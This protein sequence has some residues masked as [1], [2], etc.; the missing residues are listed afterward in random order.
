MFTRP[1]HQAPA[2]VPAFVLLLSLGMLATLSG[3][4]LANP[5]PDIII[6][7]HVQETSG[8]GYCGTTVTECASV[9]QSTTLTGQLDFQF[10]Y[11]RYYTGVGEPTLIEMTVEWPAG[12]VPLDA[13][14][15]TGYGD[16]SIGGNSAS[17]TIYPDGAPE[18][19]EFFLLAS[20]RMFAGP[21]QTSFRRPINVQTIP[22]APS[23]YDWSASGVGARVGLECG[24]CSSYCYR[25]GGVGPCWPRFDPNPLTLTAAVGQLASATVRVASGGLTECDVTYQ[26]SEP[27]MQL[28]VVPV[29]P[30]YEDDVTVTADATGLSPG[31]Y[32][33]WINADVGDCYECGKV[34]LTVVEG[35]LVPGTSDPWLAGMPDGS[36]ASSGDVAPAQSPAQV[37]G[38]PAV[39]GA[40][41]L[42]EATGGV[43]SGP[44][45][46]L[47]PPDGDAGIIA[48]HN[49]GVEN[50]ISSLTAPYHCLVGIFLDDGRPDLTAAP[51]S[52]DFSTAVSR[53]YSTLRPELKQPF[54][55]GDG[56]TS[57]GQ[58]QG[59]VVS[60]GATR[61]FLGTMDGGGWYNNE[62]S[63]SVAVSKVDANPGRKNSIGKWALH[64]AGPTNHK[65]NTCDMTFDCYDIQGN[66]PSGAGR[67][68]I[69]VIGVDVDGVAK[70]WYGL[71]CEGSFYF[72]GWRSCSDYDFPSD[73]WPGCGEGI[74]Q[75][76]TTEQPGPN[77][78]MGILDV[79]VY[80]PGEIS[81]SDEPR[82]GYTKW[83]DGV[84]EW[85]YQICWRTPS[86]DEAISRGVVGFGQPGYV[87]CGIVPVQRTTWGALK[88]LYR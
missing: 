41:W 46:P 83:C 67:S 3:L 52:L 62:G 64:Y 5:V 66:A 70:T 32:H 69:Y 49:N 74:V 48:A 51:A 14:I 9:A 76:W 72:Y 16:M 11:H 80:G 24:N 81:I 78:T 17:F 37:T 27:W 30:R 35:T 8:S 47:S 68:D 59:V 55:I 88:A 2:I 23:G 42:F 50:G 13:E 20:L 34:I 26:A 53:D 85:N 39:P 84:N 6:Y 79:Y 19:D 44:G 28:D 25:S 86:S 75:E 12:W 33:G 22:P 36:T 82:F 65:A 56:V 18:V 54:F 57:T 38:I 63:F 1:S 58:R 73:N 71:S 7:T 10:F 29:Y 45:V 87:P 77:V 60:E 61:L 15:C 21:G 43:N 31:V 4:G 40:L